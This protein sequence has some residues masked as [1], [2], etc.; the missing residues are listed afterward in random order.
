MLESSGMSTLVTVTL[1]SPVAV[2]APGFSA[3]A[4]KVNELSDCFIP[5]ALIPLEPLG[6]KKP[7]AA[8]SG[9]LASVTTPFTYST[10]GVQRRVSDRCMCDDKKDVAMNS[11][12]INR[13]Q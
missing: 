3:F 4:F 6:E 8:S 9:A 7:V 12:Q 13:Q 11:L 2:P 5:A 10:A 1:Q